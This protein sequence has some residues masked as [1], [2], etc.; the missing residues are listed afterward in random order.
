[1]QTQGQQ[2]WI[3]DG[4]H[5][6]MQKLAALQMKK[7]IHITAIIELDSNDRRQKA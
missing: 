4:C 7:L 1:M 6:Y 5:D 2:S 3:W